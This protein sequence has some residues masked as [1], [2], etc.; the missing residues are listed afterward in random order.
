M[1]IFVVCT[2][3]AVVVID[4]LNVFTVAQNNEKLQD[5]QCIFELTPSQADQI[6]NAR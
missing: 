6:R 5:S 3:S 2:Y 4:C 1:H